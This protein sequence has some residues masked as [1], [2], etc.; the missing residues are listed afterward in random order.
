MSTPFD[1]FEHIIR[2][3]ES[4][5]P[6]TSL[7]IGGPAEYFAEPTSLDELTQLVKIA[8]KEE[9]PARLLGSGSNVLIGE[10]GFA[11]LILHLASAEFCSV[12]VD[13]DKMTVGG[14]CQL[15]HFISM[16]AREALAG[17]EVLAGIPGTI[18]GALH[19]NADSNGEDIGQWVTAATV[20]TLDGEV[21]TRSASELNFAYR[22][23]SLTELVILSAEFQFKKGD[24]DEVTRRMQKQWI[25]RRASQPSSEERAAYVFKDPI[26]STADSLIESVGLK[27]TRVGAVEIYQ[28]NANFFVAHNGATV[29]DVLKLI[30]VC[31]AQVSSQVGVELEAGIDIW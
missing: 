22:Q 10:N 30:D 13:G 8:A 11:G 24:R 23:S 12:N 15:S 28:P 16:A 7:G 6:F 25:V 29:E 19:G 26:G 9:I 14:G 21:H 4:L 1:G 2:P 20:L 31:K 18:G 17:P 27:G 3:N 5:A